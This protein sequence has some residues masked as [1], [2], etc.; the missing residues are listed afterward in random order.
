MPRSE[1]RAYNDVEMK[2]SHNTF[3]IA[4]PLTTLRAEGGWEFPVYDRGCR[5]VEL[6]VAQYAGPAPGN[7]MQWSVQHDED[8]SLHNR[9]LS[10]FLAELRAWSEATPGHDVLTVLV[11][12][13]HVADHAGFPAQL[14]AYVD[15][16]LDG[17]GRP[18][19]YTPG[20]LLARAP[21]AADLRTAARREGWP[22][23]SELRGRFV[24]ML[25]GDEASLQSYAAAPA[26]RMGFACVDCP[27]DEVPPARY[28]DGRPNQLFLNYHLYGDHRAT[29]ARH[30]RAVRDDPSILFRGYIVQDG[31]WDDAVAAGVNMLATDHVT[32]AWPAPFRARPSSRRRRPPVG[33]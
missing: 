26:G 3:Q 23:L 4:W 30:F 21:G 32:H 25:T 10:Q 15:A 22:T 2:A 8:Y 9:Q 14:D 1:S 24:V 7:Y 20:D 6:D 12:L 28:V 13:K 27:D 16:F 19:L 11:C 31:W 33:A 17:P 5:A 29:W 18:R